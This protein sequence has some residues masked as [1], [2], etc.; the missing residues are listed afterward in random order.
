MILTLDSE[1][2]PQ[3]SIAGGHYRILISGDDTGGAYAV[4]E[5]QVPPGGGPLPHAHPDM[6]EMFYVAEG[7]ITFKTVGRKFQASK[8]AFINIPFGGDIHAFKNTSE[9]P[10]KLVCTVIP[11][12]LEKM[13]KEVSEATPA[14]ARAISERYGSKVYP[15]DFLD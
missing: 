7:E 6:Q 10:A 14:E 4:I 9:Q 5:M 15:A 8:G 2:G 12:G 3:L 13:F 11:A 1:K